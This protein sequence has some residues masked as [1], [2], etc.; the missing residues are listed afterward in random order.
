[1]TGKFKRMPGALN[2]IAASLLAAAG[3]SALAE[4]WVPT[5][6]SDDYNAYAD[7]SSIRRQGDFVKMSSL[8]DYKTPRPGAAG[9]TYL[10]T[11]RQF[12]Y[13][14]KRRQARALGASSYAEHEGKGGVLASASA[15]YDWKPVVPDSADEFLLNYACTTTGTG[16]TGTAK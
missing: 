6:Q 3:A 8:F 7:P 2:A 1:M 4:V 12:E 11:K 9:K 16:S 10:S 15:P 13:D 14:C 5:S